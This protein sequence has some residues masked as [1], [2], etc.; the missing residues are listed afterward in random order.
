MKYPSLLLRGF[1]C[2]TITAYDTFYLKSGLPILQETKI[3][4]PTE[5]E[6]SLFKA[7]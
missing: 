2:L 5:A 3:I 1:L 4:S 7:A 6:G